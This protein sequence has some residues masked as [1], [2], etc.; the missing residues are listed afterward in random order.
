MERGC[1]ME[2][3]AGRYYRTRA[4]EKAYVVG[5]NPFR[6]RSV[7]HFVVAVSGD[8][9]TVAPEGN[10]LSDAATDDMDLVSEWREPATQTVELKMFRGSGEP[11]VVCAQNWETTCD[12]IAR[13]SVQITE[14]EGMSGD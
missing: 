4:G 2:V 12:M 10:Y 9:Y 14:G 11:F 13:K 7:G 8:V 5:A 1:E 3:T 6:D